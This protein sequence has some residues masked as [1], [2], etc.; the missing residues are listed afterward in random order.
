MSENAWL[1]EVLADAKA[2]KQAWPAW[3]KAGTVQ[4]SLNAHPVQASQVPPAHCQPRPPAGDKTQ[5]D[6]GL[7]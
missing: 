6:L 5:N 7:K 2:A 3:A 1:K 4:I